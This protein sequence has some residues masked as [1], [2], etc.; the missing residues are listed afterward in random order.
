MI[1]I[2]GSRTIRKKG[3]TGTVIS[4]VGQATEIALRVD[5]YQRIPRSAA[6]R[7][8]KEFPRIGGGVRDVT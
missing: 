6:F 2:R 5:E 3:K 4:P 1:G 7:E 8:A